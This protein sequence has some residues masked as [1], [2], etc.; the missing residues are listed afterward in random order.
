MELQGWQKA[1]GDDGSAVIGVSQDTTKAYKGNGSLKVDVKLIKGTQEKAGVEVYFAEPVD[2]TGK[3]LTIHMYI[4]PNLKGTNNGIQIFAKDSDWSYGAGPWINVSDSNVG[5][6]TEVTL[7]FDNPNWSWAGGGSDGQLDI[8]KIKAIG[9][10]IL[11]GGNAP[12]GETL[13]GSYW[14]DSINY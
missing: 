9:I 12:A 7:N 3:T 8:T 2:M 10:K 14:L 13:E 5:T 11:M 6:W 1:S 4:D